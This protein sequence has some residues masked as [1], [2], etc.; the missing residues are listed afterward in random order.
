VLDRVAEVTFRKLGVHT[1]LEE[2][3]NVLDLVF[4]N[5]LLLLGLVL[6]LF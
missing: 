6:S 5:E 4:G 3:A 1:D 2:V